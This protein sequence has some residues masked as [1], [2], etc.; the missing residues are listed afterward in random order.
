MRRL[1]SCRRPPL[2]PPHPAR[3]LSDLGASCFYECKEADEV[4]GRE[5]VVD[6]W[7]DGLWAPLA[8][9]YAALQQVWG[10]ALVAE[11]WAPGCAALQTAAC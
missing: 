3:R 9:A 10:R 2:A 7:T 6:G 11:R 1:L 8:A 5:E 4:D